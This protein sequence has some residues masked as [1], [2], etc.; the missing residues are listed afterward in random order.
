MAS[1]VSTDTMNPVICI[2][3]GLNMT[4]TPKIRRSLGSKHKGSSI[5]VYELVLPMWKELAAL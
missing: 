4:E 2:A 3:C 5:E 1:S